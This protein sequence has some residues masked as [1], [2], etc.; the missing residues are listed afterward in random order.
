M[1][2]RNAEGRKLYES[3]VP[4]TLDCGSTLPEVTI[5]YESWGELNSTASNA[6]L[7]CHALTS[8]C[9]VTS[10][11]RTGVRPGW[12]ERV[13]GPGC[14]IDTQRYFVLCANVLGGCDGSTG[15]AAL[16][17]GTGRRYG[18]RLPAISVADMVRAQGILLDHFGIT[19]LRAV[20]GGCFGGF[21]ALTWGI[22][23][24]QRA[25]ALLLIATRLAS[26]SYGIA[27]WH[28]LRE[29]IRLDP[30]WRGGDYYDGTPPWRGSGLSA[31]IGLLH[32]MAP[33]LMEQRYGRSRRSEPA[34]SMELQ[35]E[36]EHMLA[37]V[38]ARAEGGM[39]PN[40]MIYLTRAMDHFD[41]GP[42]IAQLPASGL[43]GCRA[44]IVNYHRDVRYSPEAGEWMARTL[45]RAGMRTEFHALSS[46]ISHGGFLLDPDGVIPLIGNFVHSLE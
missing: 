22:T 42:T 13:V 35:F 11:G 32:W 19:R 3:K 12:W 46:A 9:H 8:D 7:I 26:S 17:P 6:I 18:M 33:E 29:A 37:G 34:D 38:M 1:K 39:D 28:V 41:V 23:Q 21:Q 31:V 25:P 10:A 2:D 14:A 20:I 45:C 5:A 24:P 16:M 30:N 43:S 36:V 44:L 4:L 40:T 27:L 15:P